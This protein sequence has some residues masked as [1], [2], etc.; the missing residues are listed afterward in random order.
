MATSSH[1][2]TSIGISVFPLDG[3]D[4]ATL[5]KHAD[6]A[7]YH[8]KE[9]GRNGYQFFR[10]DMN[11]RAVER[12]QVESSLRL[13]L[14]RSEFALHYQPKLDLQSGA[15]TGVEALLRWEHPSG[16]RCC[17]NASTTS[18]R[19]AAWSF[20]SEAGYCVRPA[21]KRCAGAT[22]GWRRSRSR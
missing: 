18:R 19:S 17:R 9:R 5:V 4:A 2:S 14:D 1:T 11:V 16:G 10:H 3:P 13:A 20:R 6:T 22:A 8:A 7:M 21:R 15:I 12:Q